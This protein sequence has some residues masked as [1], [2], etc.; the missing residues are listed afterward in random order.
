VLFK[1]GFQSVFVGLCTLQCSLIVGNDA[2]A[3]VLMRV[4]CLHSGGGDDAVMKQGW[5]SIGMY[6]ADRRQWDKAVLYFTQ[7]R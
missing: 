4:Y 6:Y 3:F 1:L 2:V 7:V 5:N